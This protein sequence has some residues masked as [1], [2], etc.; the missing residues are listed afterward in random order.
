MRCHA[1]I[2]FRQAQNISFPIL[3]P[4]I[5]FYL[6]PMV[7]PQF[8]EARHNNASVILDVDY[9]VGVEVRDAHVRDELVKFV[10]VEAAKEWTLF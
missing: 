7:R 2:Q 3:G 4:N 8:N 5:G 6:S 9:L 1:R 10:N